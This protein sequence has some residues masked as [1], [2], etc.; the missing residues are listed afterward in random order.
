[1]ALSHITN[2]FKL[3]TP[4]LT[5]VLSAVFYV[6]VNLYEALLSALGRLQVKGL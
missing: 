6:A 4:V 2:G 3:Q 5:G 1:M